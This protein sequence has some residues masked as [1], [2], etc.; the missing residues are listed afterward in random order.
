MYINRFNG[1]DANT[2]YELRL[3]NRIKKNRRNVL[4]CINELGAR[5]SDMPTVATDGQGEQQFYLIENKISS[6]TT[7]DNAEISLKL[8]GV[9]PK[10]R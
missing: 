1:N 7:L 8:N 10:I 3:Y 4:A 5:V 6:T 9:M 2:K